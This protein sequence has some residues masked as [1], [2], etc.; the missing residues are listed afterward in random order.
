MIHSPTF[1]GLLIHKKVIVNIFID[2]YLR[3]LNHSAP[4][5]PQISLI[6]GAQPQYPPPLYTHVNKLYS[7]NDTSQNRKQLEAEDPCVCVWTRNNVQHRKWTKNIPDEKDIKAWLT[8]IS[9]VENEYIRIPGES[10][11]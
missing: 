4:M 1:Q 10:K 11:S 8:E 2:F 3:P 9:T 6:Q 7:A 5:E